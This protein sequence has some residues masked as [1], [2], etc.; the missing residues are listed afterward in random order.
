[1]TNY[2]KK[3]SKQKQKANRIQP[4]ILGLIDTAFDNFTILAGDLG[5]WYDRPFSRE[6]SMSPSEFKELHQQEY[7]GIPPTQTHKH[8]EPESQ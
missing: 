5:G 7:P 4:S 2:S 8:P 6:E 3:R 1:V